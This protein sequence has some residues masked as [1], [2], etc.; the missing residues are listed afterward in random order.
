MKNIEIKLKLQRLKSNW[1]KEIQERYDYYR[2]DTDE[3]AKI[4]RGIAEELGVYCVDLE[5]LISQI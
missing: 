3:S 5:H 2:N 4:G 1:E